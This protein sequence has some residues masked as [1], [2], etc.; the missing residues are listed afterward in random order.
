MHFYVNFE[1]LN[2]T[3]KDVVSLHKIFIAEDVENLVIK[4]DNLQI[5]LDD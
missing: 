2:C 1:I 4:T 5:D 3:I